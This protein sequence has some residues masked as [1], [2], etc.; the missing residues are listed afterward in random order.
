MQLSTVRGSFGDLE[1]RTLRPRLVAG[2]APM[3]TFRTA[4]LSSPRRLAIG[5]AF[6]IHAEDG[7]RTQTIVGVARAWQPRLLGAPP[8]RTPPCDQTRQRAD[9]AAAASWVRFPR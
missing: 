5:Y 3:T 6:T 1:A 2:S 7:R 8:P 4:V 9:S